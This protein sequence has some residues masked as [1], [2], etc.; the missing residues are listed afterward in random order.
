MAKYE[1]EDLSQEAKAFVKDKKASGQRSIEE[2]INFFHP[3][4]Q[5]DKKSDQRRKIGNY[6]MGLWAFWIGFGV[7]MAFLLMANHI[8]AIYFTI[9]AGMV[10]VFGGL[11]WLTYR[12]T[13]QYEVRDLPNLLRSFLVPFLKLMKDRFGG[14]AKL[15]LKL[16][17]S[18]IDDLGDIPAELPQSEKLH[19][20]DASISE[21]GLGQWSLSLEAVG[22]QVPFFTYYKLKHT[23]SHSV[24]T[25]R[26]V[27]DIAVN[28]SSFQVKEEAGKAVLSE[29]FSRQSEVEIESDPGP[30]IYEFGR[31]LKNMRKAIG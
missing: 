26:A 19:Y 7:F 20:M 14:D 1:F 29:E 23:L 17:L 27:S 11:L 10:L 9:P 31:S 3:L 16:D 22:V 24:I 4:A 13:R 6:I 28:G 21:P 30:D 25:D 2:W 12:W 15:D 5:F 18:V 8:E